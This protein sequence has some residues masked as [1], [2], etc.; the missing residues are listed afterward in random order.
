[1]F[2]VDYRFAPDYIFPAQLHDLQ[3]ARTWLNRHAEQYRLDVSQVSGFGFSSGAHLIALMALVA[4]S[5][6]ADA[7]ADALNQPYGG[8]DTTLS[9]VGKATGFLVRH[10]NKR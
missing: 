10:N 2:N 8:P 1:M 7:D 9:A 5:D 6:D 4:S 3:V